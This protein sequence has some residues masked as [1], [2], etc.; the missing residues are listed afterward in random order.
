MNI[1][2][3]GLMAAT[4]L[5]TASCT[6]DKKVETTTATTPETVT[7]TTTTTTTVDT[8]AVHDEARRLAARMAEDLKLSDPAVVTRI[9]RTYYTRGQRLGEANNRYVSDTVGRY[10]ALRQINDEADT[11]I[12]TDLNNPGYYNT[13]S[14][15]RA[16]YGDG[17][18]SLA[19][20][21]VTTTSATTSANTTRRG[22]VGQGSG[23]KKVDNEEDGDRKTKYM[24]GA[25]VKRDDDGSVKIKMA[26][27][28]KVKIDEN[29]NRTVKKSLFK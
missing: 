27:G 18:Y 10:A 15:N 22:T 5:A 16:N 7:T 6:Q 29:G 13:Y 14:T 11:E 3:L 23:V 25:K 24:N 12:R 28:T 2:I 26:N 20:G 21:T 1:K 19:P 9:E 8:V 4:A 17:P